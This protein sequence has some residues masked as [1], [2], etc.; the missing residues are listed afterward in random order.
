MPTPGAGRRAAA[1]VRA[2]LRGLWIG[3]WTA[4]R[5]PVWP[6]LWRMIVRIVAALLALAIVAVLL[7]RFVLWPQAHTAREWLEHQG[8][9]A[10]SA[11]L[12]IGEL[13]TYWDGWHPAFRARD[14]R[15]VDAQQR[16]LLAAGSLDGKLSW[17]SVPTMALQFVSLTADR[18]DVLIRR[19][20]EGKLLVAGVPVETQK[21]GAQDDPFLHW[22]LSQGRIDLVS[23]N[24]RWL[25]EKARLPQLDVADIHFTTERD[26]A[27]HIVRLEAR[28]AALAPRPLV[29][30]ANLRHDYLHGTGNWQHWTGQASWAFNQL[31]LPVVQRYLAIFDSVQDGVFSTDG[32]VDFR[33]GQV[34]RSQMRLR[35]SG[36]DLHLA[37]APEPLKLANAQ[38]LLLHKSDRNGNHQLTIDTLLWQAEP[39]AGPPSN[40]DASWREGM[41]KV[42]IDWNRDSSGQLRKFALRAPTFDLNTLRALATSM[43]LDTAVLRQLRALQPAGHIDN[44]DVAWSRDR[45]GLLSRAPGTQHYN[46]QGTLRNVSVNGQPAVPAVDA[47]GLPRAGTPGFSQLSGSFN[48]D[49]KQGVAR[50]DTTGGAL[51]FPGVFEDPRLPFDTLR[52]EVRWTH[53]GDKLV[54]RT[55]GIQFANA[56][57]AG[58]VRGTWRQGGDSHAGVADLTG[59]LE[60]AQA[61]RVP[62][63]M[64]LTLPATR[65]YLA[66]ALVGGEAHDVKFLVKGD[67][68]HFPFHPPLAKAGDFRVEVP[69]RRVNYQI[70]PDETGPNGASGQKA[71][72]AWPEFTD[73]EG[74]VMFER[75]SMSFLAKRA[76]VA[77]IQ[78]VTLRDVSGRIEDMGDHGHLQVDG[79]ASG[80]VQSFLRFVAT[81]PV[82]EWTANVTETSHA[83]GNGELKLKL[84][85]PLNH[86]AGSKVNG[87]FRFPGNDVTLFPELPTLYGATGAVAF[88]EHGFRLDNVRGRFVGGETRLGGGTQ[89]DGTTRV[90]VSG[91]ATAQGLREALG[92]EMS[93]LGSRI[94]GTSAYSAV[95]GVHDK[96]LQVEVASS[97]NG[98]ALDLPAP[99][100]KTAAQDMP[101]RFDLRPSTAPGRAGLDEVT[102]QLGNAASARYVLRRG[103]DALEVVS[104]GIGL[105]QSAP[106]P[107]SGV[108][109]AMTTDRLNVDA[110]RALLSGPDNKGGDKPASDIGRSSPFLPDRMT[111]RAKVLDAF[112]RSLDDVSLDAGRERGDGGWNMQINSRQIAGTGQ[113]RRNASNPSGMLTVRL[114]H[115][116]I[117]DAT[118]DGHMTEAITRSVEE[119]PALDL[120]VDRFVLH[121]REFGK[122][123]VKAHTSH[124][125]NQP[126]WTLDSLI[127]EQPGAKLTGNGSWRLPRRLREAAAQG[128]ASSTEGRRTLLNFKL[129]IRNGGDV[130]E[131]MGLPH[132]LRDGKGT[133]EGRIAWRGS[134]MSID[135]PTLSG[136]LK[137]NIENG[138]I[139]SVD[140]GAARL[141]GVLSLQSLL[142]FATLDFRSLSS[143][144]MVFDS[145]NGTGTI[146]NGVGKIEEFKFKSGQAMASMSGTADLLHETQDLEVAVTPRINATTT[147][148]AAAFINPVLG[149]GT[150]AAQLMFA[151]EISKVFTQHYR[152]SG[153]W[154]D[155]KVTKV[156]DNKTQ[157]PIQ[158]RSGAYPR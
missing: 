37:G 145:L 146:E 70:A 132:T 108:T 49:D 42:T 58:A 15:A 101:L 92:T 155:P 33:G 22:L 138:Q 27:Q 123:E 147:S 63:Y 23:G 95:V 9:T 137:L 29:F 121:G 6:R 60:R 54:V 125:D 52:G 39:Q 83:P 35:A 120:S 151:D 43:P 98:L 77:G 128:D 51:I 140:P 113:W 88:D 69:V 21:T 107:A 139:L 154:A 78:G 97:L 126:V 93:A 158:E 48:F 94:D 91:T 76:G 5:H 90:T 36:V 109:V 112:G 115:L 66:G 7:I 38:A 74:T 82:K 153:S 130:L 111:V 64:P 100:A 134:P 149:I 89:P 11:R 19:T 110:W 150:L 57:T 104:G 124:D 16:V 133:F 56:D 73:I 4:V 99:L 46:V 156:E 80:P 135:Y 2:T 30:Q 81:S 28:S 24:L 84:D 131:R 87:E 53:E 127:I 86:A 152:V 8:S 47:D 18:T 72:T 50:V 142:R 59:E 34:Q 141:L 114:A 106:Q 67:L 103:G 12:T 116:D 62:R 40:A 68:T 20:P 105:G 157:P 41:R 148:V 1:F 143:R 13:D 136:R 10:L 144:G 26:G 102:V 71:G 17:Q 61:N 32:T 45:A 85:L 119:M 129:D 75:G 118:D 122:L 55:D 3:L 65:H 14:V 96:H 31:E 79:S 117:P 25:D 44:L